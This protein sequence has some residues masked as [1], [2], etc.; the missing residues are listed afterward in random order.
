MDVDQVV[1]RIL[2]KKQATVG[3]GAAGPQVDLAEKQLG[4]KFPSELRRYL[5]RFGWL[6]VGPYEVY[7][8]G[9]DVLPHMDIV[10]VTVEEREEVEPSLPR[11][12]V[13]LMNDGSG[14]FYCVDVEKSSIDVA[15]V[16]YFDHAL[17][18][19]QDPIITYPSIAR[20]LEDAF[21]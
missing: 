1:L 3:A 19:D 11:H 2:H 10:A 7:G 8:V 12:L 14:S 4:V 5:E 20:W 13:P 6:I 9:S 21:L 18:K 16:V 17:G 15:Q